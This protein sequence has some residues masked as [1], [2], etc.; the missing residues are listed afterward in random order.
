MIAMQKHIFWSSS[1]MNCISPSCKIFQGLHFHLGILL[2]F[3]VAVFIRRK[4]SDCSG[5]LK[6]FGVICTDKS[7]SVLFLLKV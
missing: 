7:R 2:S 4:G 3:L 1:L 6:C 5:F